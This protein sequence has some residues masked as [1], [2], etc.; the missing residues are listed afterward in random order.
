MLE[1]LVLHHSCLIF[2]KKMIYHNRDW[3]T[4]AWYNID[5]LEILC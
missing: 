1:N 3:N 4:D 5:E 2:F